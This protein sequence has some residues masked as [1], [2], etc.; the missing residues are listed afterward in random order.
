M[1]GCSNILGRQMS[2]KQNQ[3]NQ[4]KITGTSTVPFQSKKKPTL[5]DVCK[6]RIVSFSL[7]FHNKQMVDLMQV[8]Q[9]LTVVIK[10][11]K[12]YN[13]TSQITNHNFT[14]QIPLKNAILFCGFYCYYYYFVYDVKLR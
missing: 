9:Q 2:P 12:N 1:K 14:D 11:E 6:F 5:F 10:M 4:R 13:F 8:K 7:F 3:V